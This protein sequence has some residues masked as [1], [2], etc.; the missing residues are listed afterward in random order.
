M[1]PVEA[2]AWDQAEASTDTYH[3]AKP[4]A[5]ESWA[6]AALNVASSDSAIDV[7]ETSPDCSARMS[8]H[9]DAPAAMFTRAYQLEMLDQSLKHNAII[10]MDTGSGK[11][12]V[13]VLRIKAE[14]EMSGPD[15]IIWFLAPTVALCSQQFHVIKLQ[16]PAVSMKLITGQENLET[17][18]AATWKTVLR[19]VRI[20]VSTYQVLHDA[21]CHSFIKMDRLSLIVFDEAHNCSGRH[22]GTKI[23]KDFYHRSKD[24]SLPVPSILG[25]TA[26]PSMT[27]DIDNINILE[28][29]LDGKCVTPTLHR[30]DLFKCVKRPQIRSILYSAPV[31]VLYTPL[32]RRL[33][34]EFQRLDITKDPYILRLQKDP[35]ERNHRAFIRAIEKYDTF[36]Q[37]QIRGLRNRSVEIAQQLGSWAADFYIWKSATSFLERLANDEEKLFENWIDSERQYVAD[38]LRR[39]S[40]GRPPRMPQNGDEISDKASALIKELA[41]IDEPIVCIIFATERATVGVLCDLLGSCPRIV[42]KHRIGSIVGSSNYQIKRNALYEPPGDWSPTAL[43]DFRS[44]KINILIATSVLEEGIDVPACNM[45]VCFDHPGTPKSFVQ[46][47]GRARMKDSTLLLMS[48]HSS[49]VIARWE[50]L[51]EDMKVVYQD[52]QREIT[53]L[54]QLE[55]SEATCP[56]FFRVESTGARLDFDN[57][58]PHLEH[59]CRVLSA[60]EFIDS[61]PDYIIHRHEESTPPTLSA[62]VLL[63]SFVPTRL[64][65]VDGKLRWLS[66]R[67]ATKEAAFEAYRAL[68]EAGMVNEHLL[69]F[70]Y[71]DIQGVEERT[72]EV[73][74]EALLDP[75]P[76]VAGAWKQVD[77]LWLYSLTFHDTEHFGETT[78]DV[79]LPS[80]L[81]QWQPIRTYLSLEEDGGRIVCDS[82]RPISAAEAAGLPDHTSSLLALHFGHRWRVEERSHVIKISARG[83]NMSLEDI[84]GRAFDVNDEVMTGRDYLIRDGVR[85][86]Y[87]YLN[88]V[89]NK[90][91]VEQIQN[92]MRDY[93]LAPEDVPYLIVKKWTRRTDFLHPVNETSATA[94][95]T[96]TKKLYPHVLPLPWARVDTVPIK[97]ARL[98][99]LIPSLIHE[100]EVMMIVKELSETL[101][102]GVQL[103]RLDLVRAAISSGNAEEPVNYER[104]EFLGDSVLKYLTAIQVSAIQPD[105]PE[106]YLSFFKDR[107]V[108]NSRLSRAAVDSGLAKFILTKTFT[109]HRWRPLYLAN[110]D[111][112][113]TAARPPRKMS[114]KTLADVTE[115]LI[116]ASYIDGGTA[117]AQACISVFVNEIR[118]QDVTASRDFFYERAR[119]RVVASPELDRLEELVG[120]RFGKKSLLVEALTHPSCLF[121][122][123][124]R[125]YEHLEFLGDAVLDYVIVRRLYARTPPL[126]HH[127]MHIFKTAMVNG[128]FL[129]FLCLHHSRPRTETVVTAEAEVLEQEAGPPLA[130]WNFMRHSSESIAVEQAALERRFAAVR[131]DVLS[132]LVDGAYYPWALLARM[133]AP[134]FYS[135]LMEAL[136]GAV[137]VDSGSV[138]ECEALLARLGVLSYLDRLIRDGVQVQHPKELLGKYAVA[139]T[140]TYKLDAQKKGADGETR[141][142]CRVS[143]GSNVVAEVFDGV[144]REE[145]KIKAA[146]AAVRMMDGNQKK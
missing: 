93:D 31:D 35:T 94:A 16:V 142:S 24:M 97:F 22:P 34:D 128:D 88:L 76:A 82:R 146:D 20:V 58:K 109:G 4:Y 60:G 28:A 67:N 86:P 129:A 123:D 130:L 131:A 112:D 11:T 36:A 75:W 120:Y 39:V 145:V 137:W 43:E 115:A 9:G 63:P 18:S 102:R 105:W 26:T 138:Q 61:R 21:L 37:N 64:R 133:Q 111:T 66:E 96:T 81:D 27:E 5:R 107:I 83:T 15:K 45:V 7:T 78:I 119:D 95:T 114:T 14:L 110:Y 80:Q 30:D 121:N 65:V 62:S 32:M 89:S 49:P 90:P 38:F 17:W 57:A 53:H 54:R 72:S 3:R 55:E 12:H 141:F 104:L 48:E 124:T 10:V 143:I 116:G 136:L 23:M 42:E 125:S 91:P 85:M 108:S 70:K 74:A 122:H 71:E 13:A 135:D 99:M 69:P 25:I 51:E 41:A 8:C 44:G 77:Q 103:T 50:A 118:W 113:S 1:Y 33:Q 144:S 19:D 79:V 47:R 117:K 100:M 46:R 101:L 6:V 106:G 40:P 98:G 2:A 73:E 134:K 84:G 127:Q 59:F 56:T 126:A 139:Q 92:G 140:V 52:T 87:H 68:Y 29:T 132:A